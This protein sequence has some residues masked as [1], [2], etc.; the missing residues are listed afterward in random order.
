MLFVEIMGQEFCVKIFTFHMLTTEE[1][2]SFVSAHFVSD[3]ADASIE[4]ANNYILTIVV[5]KDFN[6]LQCRLIDLVVVFS[7]IIAR[8]QWF[9]IC[10]RNYPHIVGIPAN[11]R[12][13][14]RRRR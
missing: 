4:S 12:Q 14:L 1:T 7:S 13:R 6:F 3:W 11:H 8:D 10:D 2:K 5:K 9:I